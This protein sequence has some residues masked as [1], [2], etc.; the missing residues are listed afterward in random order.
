MTVTPTPETC[1]GNGAL[2]FE[3]ENTQNEAE[4]EF[5]IYQTSNLVT[6][7]RVGAATAT[8]TTLTHTEEGLL[9]GTYN[10]VVVQT[11]EGETNQQSQNNI[12]IT[13]SIQALAFT[14]SQTRKCGNLVDITTNVTAGHPDT[15]TLY[16]N[17]SNVVRPA[18]A[19]NV[20]EDVP[21]GSYVVA[22][23][24]VC[25]DVVSLGITV[26]E[27][28]VNYGISRGSNAYGFVAL[29]DCDTFNHVE[30]LQYNGT[31]TIPAHRYPID[32]AIEVEDPN[33]GP[34]TVIN[35]TWIS[36]NSETFSIPYYYLASGGTYSYSVT[37]TDA[38]G[39]VTTQTDDIPRSSNFR[40]RTINAVCG[41]K[42]LRIDNYYRLKNP[43]AKITFVSYPLGFDPADY[44]NDFVSGAYTHTYTSSLGDINFGD[45]TTPVPVGNYTIQIED[46]CGRITEQSITV[47]NSVNY[48]IYNSKLYGGCGDDEG[49][50]NLYIRAS[51]ATIADNMV[52]VKVTSAPAAF[53]TNYGVLPYDVSANIASNGQFYMNSLPAGDYTINVV[54]E[55]GI[56]ITHTFTVPGANLVS[57]VTP[58]LNCG[59]FDVSYEISSYLAYE[60]IYL[61]KYYPA[62]GRWGHPSTGSLYTNGAVL[63]TTNAMQFPGVGGHNGGLQ[64]LTGSFTNLVQSGLFRVILQSYHYDNGIA[65]GGNGTEGRL[66]CFNELEQFTVPANGI[67]LN[68]YYVAS[69]AGGTTELI[70]DAVSG[71]STLNYT[72][73]EQ[74][75]TAV[76]IDN[77]TSPVFTGLAPG[78]Y[79]VRITDDCPNEVYFEFSTSTVKLPVIRP[80]NLCEGEN[81]SLFVTGL[82]F[83]DITWTKDSDP[84]VIGTG[85]TLNFTPFTAT[86]AGTYHATLSYNPNP[87]ACINQTV[88]ITVAA[89]QPTPE[90][91]TGQTIEILQQD[92]GVMNLF[93]LITPPYD[94]YG[95]W[96]DLSGTG[97]LN[98]EVLDAGQLTVET[99]QFQYNVEGLC[100]GSDSTI[101]TIKILATDLTAHEDTITGLCPNMPQINIG[102]VMDNDTETG[103]LVTQ[104]N[105]TVSTEVADPNGII[106]V[107]AN[108]TVDVA[109][110]AQAGQTYTLQYR[111]S[112][113]A[114]TNNYAIGTLTVTFLSGIDS[115]GDGF[116][117]ICDLDDDNDGILDTDEGCRDTEFAGDNSNPTGI[118]G[119]VY[120]SYPNETS[121]YAHVRSNVAPIISISTI[122]AESFGSGLT[123][124]HQDTHVNLSNV[125][126]TTY[127]E[128]ITNNEYIEFSFTTT[129][130]F[131]GAHIDWVGFYNYVQQPGFSVTYTISNDDFATHTDL[132]TFVEMLN[133][134][135]G[136]F[137]Q[138]REAEDIVDYELSHSTTYTVRMYFYAFENGT[139]PIAFDDAI[140]AFDFCNAD[141]DGDG[142]G[143]S[144]DLDSDN[145]GIYDAVEAGVSGVNTNGTANG[146]INVATGVPANA[147]T[148]LPDTDTDGTSN[149][150]D[151]DSD[152]DNCSDADEYYQATTADGNDGGQYGEGDP[153]TLANGDVNA[154]GTVIGA[155]Y[156][157]IHYTNVITKGEVPVIETHPVGG[158]F[159]AGSTASAS[160]TLTN[161]T[162]TTLYQWQV[163][164]DDGTTWENIDGETNATISGTVIQDYNLYQFRVVVTRSDYICGEVISNPATLFIT[165]ELTENHINVN[166]YGE[167]NGSILVSATNGTAPYT[168]SLSSDFSSSNTTGSFTNL[169]ANPYTVYAK[170]ANDCTKTINVEITE[171]NDIVLTVPENETTASCLTQDEVNTLF[172]NWLTEVSYS[173]GQ[174]ASITNNSTVAPNAC[175][176][177]VTVTW[178]VTQSD[179]IAGGVH[180]QATATGS[181]GD[182]EVSDLSDD[183]SYLEDDTTTIPIEGCVIEV[184]NALT[185]DGDGRND[186]FYIRGIECYPDNTVEIY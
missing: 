29:A 115:D 165:P 53:I 44:N 46:D 141:C 66:L 68:N 119:A 37:F 138:G 22:V 162:A 74:N 67:S 122:T 32:V 179:I 88:S 177:S 104:A 17:T 41:S 118:P 144:L 174:N 95:E 49:N 55:C 35:T 20:F 71:G 185:P 72:I 60:T 31:N 21:T 110:G 15:Y 73:V 93:D 160:V 70:I 106:T 169:T 131:L 51:G 139:G 13:S 98:N 63:T 59:S 54:G 91:G 47:V 82:S 84:T 94:N 25:G 52:S 151:L 130:T 11:F 172:A 62:S 158:C 43:T 105:Y 186:T 170:D 154:N 101:V 178:T 175:G 107:N 18:Q 146:T 133:D 92:A 111:I 56:P 78:K 149:V 137:P 24:D 148:A 129:N 145:D 45:S 77:G 147:V 182:R 126:A 1:E 69:C 3:I 120:I 26:A 153:L 42:F 14:L 7:Y 90:A 64:T 184:F 87:S 85:N 48:S 40:L 27:E 128:A 38:C 102:N 142:V 183:D 50:V 28:T 123:A 83:L 134:G 16:D 161:A 8:G 58:T 159:A 116:L 171:P 167:S 155:S 117:N 9:D 173:G 33:G 80:N 166:C 108:G 113:T 81:G 140:L 76:N 127:A 2:T 136:T 176:G 109:S 180:N 112:E 100:D 5:Q 65:S 99:Y 125:N 163:S 143:N 132:A 39:V 150:C 6:P 10:V 152:A 114:N 75:G 156:T 30:R 96:T 86:D 61:Q 79:K 36:G 57:T 181:Y 19:S 157:S 4:F 34:N 121:A 168:Y 135:G 103:S 164:I 97:F 124:V 23:A 89:P 12:T